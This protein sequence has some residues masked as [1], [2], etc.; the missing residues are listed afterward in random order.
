M[1]S[2]YFY[3]G[4]ESNIAII[5]TNV[6]KKGAHLIA[7]L[8]KWPPLVSWWTMLIAFTFSAAIGIIFG[9]LP[10]NKAAK[11]SLIEALRDDTK[12]QTNS[13]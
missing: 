5:K 3:A 2:M 7:R 10:A 1:I 9:I 4:G 12:E 11:M 6:C 8:A 13:L